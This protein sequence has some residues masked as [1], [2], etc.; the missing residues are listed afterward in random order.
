MPKHPLAAVVV[1]SALATLVTGS[2]AQTFPPDLPLAVICL[3]SKTQA[4][5]GGYLETVAE[6]GTAI[7]GRERLTATLNA[8]RVVENPLRSPSPSRLLRQVLGSVAR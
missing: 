7:Y 5:V 6:D 8:Q 3:N 2:V 1:A 4:W